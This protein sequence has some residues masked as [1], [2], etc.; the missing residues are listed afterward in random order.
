[1]KNTMKIDFK[2]NTPI[3]GLSLR[4]VY[5]AIAVDLETVLFFTKKEITE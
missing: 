2:L 4:M 3:S 5:I 1:M